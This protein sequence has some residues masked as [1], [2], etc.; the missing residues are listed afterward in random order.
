MTPAPDIG[1]PEFSGEL[2]KR[3]PPPPTR[4]HE[5]WQ[6]VD[7]SLLA[8]YPGAALSPLPL[9]L[10]G[11]PAPVARSAV[12]ADIS[13]QLQ[14]LLLR[15][16]ADDH[17]ALDNFARSH[18]DPVLI[19]EG[20]TYAEQP[21][22]LH[23]PTADRGSLAM[24]R[25]HIHVPSGARAAVLVRAAGEGAGWHNTELSFTLDPEARLDVLGLWDERDTS[26]H[27]V[28]LGAALRRD[29]VLNLHLFARGSALTR[30][31][32]HVDLMEP[33]AQA[34]LSGSGLLTGSRHH[35]SL[36]QVQHHAGHCHSTQLFKHVLCDSSRSSF[37][38]T[39]YV[40]A[41][42][43]GTR[44]EQLSRHLMLS[45]KARAH[46]KPRMKIH[47]DDVSCQHGATVGRL[48]DEARH[49]LCSRGLSPAAADS[50]L[51]RA[52]AQ[53]VLDSLKRPQWRS[54]EAKSWID[55]FQDVSAQARST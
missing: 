42:A 10:A 33:G 50:L 1:W 11:S 18:Q 23:L 19:L 38:G 54:A 44:A 28:G 2:L 31:R 43:A 47:A 5:A 20:T 24:T 4:R 39:V 15:Q 32:L 52:F 30:H 8:D 40:A 7:T 17:F 41:G 3:V 46:T 22:T 49:Y 21:V 37:D 6:Y 9:R 26:Q 45:P 36:L 34:H 13:R 12:A 53:E 25:L 55:R 14:G 29:A 48:D 35:H 16:I 27:M 51:V